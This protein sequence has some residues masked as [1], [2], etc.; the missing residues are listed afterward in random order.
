MQG[1]I[2]KNTSFFII[3]F[4]LV[5]YFTIF[6]VFIINSFTHECNKKT[7]YSPDYSPDYVYL[8]FNFVTTNPTSASKSK[9]STIIHIVHAN[10]CVEL[11][12]S[13]LMSISFPIPMDG[14]PNTSAMI[15]TLK[16]KLIATLMLFN[17]NGNIDGTYTLTNLLKGVSE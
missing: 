7:G 2:H 14:C 10:S 17:T 6:S 16:P 9:P 5:I 13:L 15:A 3:I 8:S 11:R 12:V 1:N 4:L